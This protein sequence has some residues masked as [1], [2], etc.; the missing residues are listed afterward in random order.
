MLQTCFCYGPPKTKVLFAE[1]PIGQL[2]YKQKNHWISFSVLFLATDQY[3]GRQE[4]FDLEST[5]AILPKLLTAETTIHNQIIPE[6]GKKAM[7]KQSYFHGFVYI[8]L[9]VRLSEVVSA[10]HYLVSR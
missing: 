9:K 4:T 6:E 8:L 1:R 5:I 10:M 7:E 2:K 3:S